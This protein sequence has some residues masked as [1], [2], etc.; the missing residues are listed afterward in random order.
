MR[1][2]H[3]RMPLQVSQEVVLPDVRAPVESP[4]WANHHDATRLVIHPAKGKE[5]G[6][7]QPH[8]RDS[9]FHTVP[10]IL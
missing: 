5:R 3:V 8:R 6:S 2:R 7:Q 4:A 9:T 1:Q 10:R